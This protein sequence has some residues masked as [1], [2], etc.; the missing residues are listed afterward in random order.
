MR[1]LHH[2]RRCGDSAQRIDPFLHRAARGRPRVGIL[3]HH[4]VYQRLQSRQCR[5]QA[6]DVAADVLH[7]DGPAVGA[8]VRQVAGKQLVQ[9]DTQA[10]EVAAAVDLFAAQLFRAHVLRG[11]DAGAFTGQR[12]TGIHGAGDAEIRQQATAIGAAQDVVGLYVAMDHA[13]CMRVVQ[14]TGNVVHDAQRGMAV[15]R[16]ALRWRD[17]A[18]LFVL[19]R[20]VGGAIGRADV[21][22]GDDV[23]VVQ[24]RG[25][26]RF[27]Q[28]PFTQ[29]RVGRHGRRQDLQRDLSAQGIL[30]G[31]V[32][33]GHAAR[34]DGVQQR[35]A[36]NGD[37]AVLGH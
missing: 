3:R 26:A 31:E 6:R 4:R 25:D 16:G 8:L 27:L 23:G 11:A 13:L 29:Y 20:D 28:K 24:L 36:R 15:E 5:R 14:R 19:H 10:I 30:R 37:G 1:G 22:D 7:A 12:G 2:R 9:H 21:V 32:N 35:I 18:E 34:A 17:G 33:L